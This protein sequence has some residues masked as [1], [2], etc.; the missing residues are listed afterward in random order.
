V[1][2][3]DPDCLA[4]HHE[5]QREPRG[6]RRKP[7][8]RVG[9]IR[10]VNMTQCRRATRTACTFDARLLARRWLTRFQSLRCHRDGAPPA[11]PA[12]QSVATPPTADSFLQRCLPRRARTPR[13][14]RD[15]NRRHRAARDGRSLGS[16]AAATAAVESKRTRTPGQRMLAQQHQENSRPHLGSARREDGT[17]ASNASLLPGRTDVRGFRRGRQVVTAKG[18][19]ARE[20]QTVLEALRW[21]RDF[22]RIVADPRGEQ[23]RFAEAPTR[24]RGPRGLRHLDG[25]RERRVRRAAKTCVRTRSNSFSRRR[26]GA[27]QRRPISNRR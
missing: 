17:S 25:L 5:G 15:G 12:P 20:T 10:L 9:T 4:E 26:A 21:S 23:P 3:S 19:R 11:A 13:R 24:D 27:A 16:L 1:V 2:T 8:A 22:S 18:D 14:C 7:P 6:C